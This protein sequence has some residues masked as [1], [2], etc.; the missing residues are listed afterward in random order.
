MF[1]ESFKCYLEG[2]L[3]DADGADHTVRVGG[4]EVVIDE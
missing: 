2:T 1:V 4:G 3:T